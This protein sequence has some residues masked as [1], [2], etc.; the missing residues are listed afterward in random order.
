MR[1]LHSNKSAIADALVP[2]GREGDGWVGGRGAIYYWARLPSQLQFDDISPSSSGSIRGRS[3]NTTIDELAVEWLIA[4]HG[5]CIIPGTACGAPGHVRVAFANLRPDVCEE[6]AARLR[7]GLT[8][9]AS[10]DGPEELATAAA[11]AAAL[12]PPHA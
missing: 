12:A 11:A 4:Q 10:M 3:S 1:G 9:L 2:L 5:V 8:Q 6:A 7:A